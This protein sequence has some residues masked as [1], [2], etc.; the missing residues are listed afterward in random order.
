MLGEGHLPKD[1]EASLVWIPKKYTLGMVFD[2]IVNKRLQHHLEKT[3][4]ITEDQFAYRQGMGTESIRT[5][6]V[7]YISLQWRW[8]S[9]MLFTAFTTGRG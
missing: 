6:K 4:E 1:M 5:E 9:P 3:A 2:K 8:N 7:I